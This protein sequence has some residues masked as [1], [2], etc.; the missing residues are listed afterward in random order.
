MGAYTPHVSRLVGTHSLNTIKLVL[1]RFLWVA[2]NS[3]RAFVVFSLTLTLSL[4]G[5]LPRK[6]LTRLAPVNLRIGPRTA[7]SASSLS[8]CSRELSGPRSV[9]RFMRREQPSDAFTVSLVR[10]TNSVAVSRMRQPRILPPRTGARSIA[11]PVGPP[12]LR[13][14]MLRAPFR[15]SRREVVRRIL[16]PRERAG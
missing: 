15:G 1:R 10:G 12:S 13:G 16:S 8:A 3:L 9:S 14:A 7:E 5:R 6:R 4:R 2:M 11:P